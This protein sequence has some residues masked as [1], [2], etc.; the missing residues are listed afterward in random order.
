MVSI[1]G[2]WVVRFRIHRTQGNIA[3]KSEKGW[4]LGFPIK[5]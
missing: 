2:H 5:F 3:G 4:H 1:I